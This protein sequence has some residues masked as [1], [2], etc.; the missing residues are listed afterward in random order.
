MHI[1]L[2][3]A[4]AG[5]SNSLQKEFVLT[6]KVSPVVDKRSS[7]FQDKRVIS[8]RSSNH[9]Y[10]CPT[11]QI[12]YIPDITHSTLEQ[13]GDT[14]L[15]VKYLS[16]TDDFKEAYPIRGI[17][18]RPNRRL[19]VNLVCRR[20]GDD[21]QPFVNIIFMFVNSSYNTFICKNAME[22]LSPTTT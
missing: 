8:P 16:T 22:A 5:S 19:M 20:A 3:S 21:E 13:V 1:Y 2:T 12:F 9:N 4:Y 14:Y 18:Y 6:E 15:N 11:Q 10:I 7:K 17:V